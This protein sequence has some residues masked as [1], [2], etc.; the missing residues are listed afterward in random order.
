MESVEK[1]TENV[2]GGKTNY[3]QI[4]QG[5]LTAIRNF[6]AERTGNNVKL[7]WDTAFAGRNDLMRYDIMKDGK[8]VS[9]RAHAPQ[10][11]K[12]PFTFTVSSSDEARHAYQ[13]MTVDV[14]MEKA[15]SKIIV[16]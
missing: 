3:F 7:T 13:I 5:G 10:V 2:K 16:I 11:S 1:L 14:E 12:E 15:G 8:V 6:K 9:R 4:S